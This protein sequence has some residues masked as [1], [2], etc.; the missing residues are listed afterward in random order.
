MRWISHGLAIVGVVAIA[1]LARV[2]HVTSDFPTMASW[3]L[4]L[5]KE[6]TPIPEALLLE[7]SPDERLCLLAI[8]K[9]EEAK[10]AAW[11]CCSDW[12]EVRTNQCLVL[13]SLYGES[14]E[15][16]MGGNAA[17]ENPCGDCSEGQETC[18]EDRQDQVRTHCEDV[19]RKCSCQPTGLECDDP[20][21]Q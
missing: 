11:D 7:L 16:C 17:P 5:P 13:E 21:P 8:E 12:Q 18:C 1:L 2:Y 19:R 20:E 6:P 10:H 3:N 15:T 9:C 14:F 4:E